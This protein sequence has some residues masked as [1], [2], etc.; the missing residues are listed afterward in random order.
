[1]LEKTVVRE[2]DSI[3][4]S[5]EVVRQFPPVI[6]RPSDGFLLGRGDLDPDRS[7][8]HRPVPVQ[9]LPKLLLKGHHPRPHGGGRDALREIVHLDDVGQFPG[10]FD[11]KD[12]TPSDTGD[13]GVPEDA[14]TSAEPSSRGVRMST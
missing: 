9:F 1:M 5:D 11:I 7:V 14:P 4:L 3:D 6:Q 8:H 10:L 12:D 13:D 2:F